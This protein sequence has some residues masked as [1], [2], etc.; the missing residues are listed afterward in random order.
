MKISGRTTS[1]RCWSFS[2]TQSSLHSQPT[3]CS[4]TCFRKVQTTCFLQL[5]FTFLCSFRSL[6]NLLCLVSNISCCRMWQTWVMVTTSFW[7]TGSGVW[8]A[9][10]WAGWSGIH[11][12]MYSRD[13]QILSLIFVHKERGWIGLQKI[14]INVAEIIYKTL[15][16]K[17]NP[18]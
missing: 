12:Q 17:P 6:K 15:H 13:Q 4:L 10:G 9:G 16:I 5:F 7:S 11:H 18:S 3:R 1:G 8:R 14:K 2:K